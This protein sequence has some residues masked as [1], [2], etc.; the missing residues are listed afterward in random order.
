MTDLE[1]EGITK[2]NSAEVNDR[3]YL[4]QVCAEDCT[5]VGSP[6]LTDVVF[7]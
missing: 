6:R 1:I 4:S 5:L 7:F 3:L 2:G